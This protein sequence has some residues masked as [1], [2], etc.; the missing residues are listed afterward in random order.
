MIKD[1]RLLNSS[2]IETKAI[3]ESLFLVKCLWETAFAVVDQFVK[4]Y[5]LVLFCFFVEKEK[6]K[7]NSQGT[8]AVSWRLFYAI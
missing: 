4:L 8:T 5:S 6:G 2:P 7:K 3:L 1:V